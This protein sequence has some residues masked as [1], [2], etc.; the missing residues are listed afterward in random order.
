VNG[1]RIAPGGIRTGAAGHDI[2]FIHPR[3]S[4]AF[5]IAGAGVLIELVQAPEDIVAAWRERR[6]GLAATLG[7]SDCFDG[8]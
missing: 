3:P 1:V 5:P 6:D 8:A 2:C 4:D 7:R